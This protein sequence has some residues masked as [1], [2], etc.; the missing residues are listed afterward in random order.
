MGKIIAISNQKGGVGKTT[1]AINLASG[2]GYLGK[3]VLLVDFDPQGNATQ[4]VGANNDDS[5]LSVYNLIMEDYEVDQMRK[6]LVNPP[7]DLIPANISLAG[8]DLQMVQYE[9]GKEE[10]L[11]NKLDK[12][13]DEYDFIIIDCPPSLGLLNT[14]ALTAADSV[15]I[16]V[17]CEYYALEGLMQLLL[18]IRLVQQLFNPNLEVEGVVLTMFDARTKLSLEVQQEVRKHFKD[19]VYKSFIPRNVRLSESP[20]RGMSIFEYDVR[21]EGAKAYAGLASEVEKANRKGAKHE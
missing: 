6:K 5:K 9:T 3:K 1:T 10:L 19:K 21:C 18:T 17:Q 20:S 16:P 12:V 2:L 7:I 4:G 11:K 13:K 14:N 15:I 8:A